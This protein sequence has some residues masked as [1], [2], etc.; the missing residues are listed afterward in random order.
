MHCARE[1]V[2]KAALALLLFVLMAPCLLK[3]YR[4]AMKLGFFSYVYLAKPL[5]LKNNLDEC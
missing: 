4:C 3:H 5:H 1:E 2:F